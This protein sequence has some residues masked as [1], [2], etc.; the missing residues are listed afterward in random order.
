MS[1]PGPLYVMTSEKPMCERERD[2][3]HGKGVRV[4]IRQDGRQPELVVPAMRLSLSL[5]PSLSVSL[6]PSLPPYLPLAYSL[7]LLWYLRWRSMA[8]S[9]SVSRQKTF[10]LVF[11]TESLW[12]KGSGGAERDGRGERAG[13]V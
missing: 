8:L 9:V 7:S 12:M 5:A 2:L 4:E 11:K 6:P 1:V 10:I 13:G 3:A